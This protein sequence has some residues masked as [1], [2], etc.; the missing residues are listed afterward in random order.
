MFCLICGTR[1]DEDRCCPKRSCARTQCGIVFGG[2]YLGDKSPLRLSSSSS[3]QDP[4]PI[5]STNNAS[6]GSSFCGAP[7]LSVPQ[8]LPPSSLPRGWG[9]SVVTASVIIKP[10]LVS[11]ADFSSSSSPKKSA[12]ASNLT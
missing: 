10:P 3:P 2:Q 4:P 9:P 11:A 6:A 1:L 12:T 7:A 8:L 5:L